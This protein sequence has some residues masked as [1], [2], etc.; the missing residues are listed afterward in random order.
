[1]H[2]VKSESYSSG[3]N[4][5]NAVLSAPIIYWN[6]IHIAIY[7]FT[8]FLAVVWAFMP[9]NLEHYRE[10]FNE[11]RHIGFTIFI[12]LLSSVAYA[13]GGLKSTDA[14]NLSCAN[15]S[16]DLLQAASLNFQSKN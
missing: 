8:S 14:T 11:A 9:S 12:L 4:R 10:I 3:M 1:M 16:C 5:S 6:V 2:Y 7:T 13:C 15:D